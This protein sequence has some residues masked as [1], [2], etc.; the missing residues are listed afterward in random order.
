MK[1]SNTKTIF[2]KAKIFNILTPRFHIFRFIYRTFKFFINHPSYPCRHDWNIWHVCRLPT[3]DFTTCLVIMLNAYD[4]YQSNKFCQVFLKPLLL[5]ILLRAIYELINNLTS[6]GES[7]CRVVVG[8][9]IARLFPSWWGCLLSS[10]P[11]RAFH[12]FVYIHYIMQ[13][14]LATC[15]CRKS[16]K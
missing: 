3:P 2:V 8:N 4:F 7:R 9:S 5:C 1:H 14:K 12:S 6:H 11:P 16:I 13:A 15:V 10:P